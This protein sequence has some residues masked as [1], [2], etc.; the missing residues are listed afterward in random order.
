MRITKNQLRKIIKEVVTPADIAGG[1]DIPEE[2]Y[3]MFTD[4]ISEGFG[5]IAGWDVGR[6]WEEIVGY[7]LT[8][9]EEQYIIQALDAN[10][11]LRDDEFDAE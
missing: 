6:Q 3:M 4:T 2:D 9:P 10:G 1:F 8:P 5:Y 11:L 7:E